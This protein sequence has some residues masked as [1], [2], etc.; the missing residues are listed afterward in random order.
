VVACWPTASAST[1]T[2]PLSRLIGQTI[3]GAMDGRAPD[4]SLLARV[5]LGEIGGVI[6]FG[7]NVSTRAALASAIARLQHAAASGGNPPLLIAIDQEGGAVKR[8]PAGPPSAS[9]ATMGRTESAPR[10]QAQGLATGRYLRS[11]GVNVDLAPVL[12]VGNAATSFLGTRI[13]SPD[14]AATASLGSAFATGLQA[15]H[16]AA[17]AKH[18][19]GLGTAPANT[20]L[21]VVVV[22]TPKPELERRLAPFQAAVSSGIRLVMVSN[23]GYPTLDPSRLPAA[24]SPAIVGGLLRTQLGFGGVVITDTMSAPAILRHPDAPI[25]ALQAGVDVLLYSGG[26]SASVAPFSQLLA[27]ARAGRLRTAALL[28]SYGRIEALKQWLASSAG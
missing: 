28:Q 7:R 12:D 5:R 17:T 19:P 11:Y 24:L 16:V 26:E 18:F 1:P 20:D 22:P 10:V 25:L 23:A 21:R 6:I 3:V 9:A 2:P 13:F 15:A 14:P 4:A 8:L 27:A